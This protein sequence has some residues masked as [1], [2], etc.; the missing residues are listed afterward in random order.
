MKDDEGSGEIAVS[1]FYAEAPPIDALGWE[2]AMNGVEGDCWLRRP[3]G[4]CLRA[5]AFEYGA[6][7]D[8]ARRTIFRFEE[9]DNS[10][11]ISA[12]YARSGD[13]AVMWPWSQR[14]A[15]AN[16]ERCNGDDLGNRRHVQDDFDRAGYEY[17]RPLNDPQR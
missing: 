7:P 5:T 10:Y 6:G 16:V 3:D 12:D 4:V 9:D 11:A 15:R 1:Q 13:W 2:R 17:A 8:D 14:V